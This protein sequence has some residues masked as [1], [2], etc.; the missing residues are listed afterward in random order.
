MKPIR[1]ST[2][3]FPFLFAEAIFGFVY[4]SFVIKWLVYLLS[5][6]QWAVGLT[7]LIIFH[8]FFLLCQASFFMTTFTDPGEIPEGFMENSGE[9]QDENAVG[10]TSESGL[11]VEVK[12]TKRKGAKRKCNKCT[13]IKP[14][15]SHHCSQCK[16][17]TLKMDHHCPWVNNCVGF[18][19][20]KFF[21]L[22][23]TWTVILGVF[24]AACLVDPSFQLSNQKE[25]DVLLFVTFIVTGVFG[26]GLG[27]F[28]L[29]HYAYTLMNQTTIEAMEKKS[30]LYT[31]NIYHLGSYRN[32]IEVFGDNPLLWFIPVFTSKGNG[33]SF[34]TRPIGEA[35][36]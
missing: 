36:A 17:C 7:Q 28:A 21:V 10:N 3:S 34:P 11:I 9:E 4:F 8:V 31:G 27:L 22:F 29:T 15:R 23:L 18:Y 25:R 20:Y 30:N 35:I 14:D 6:G 19:N 12:E 5:Q 24:V 2:G 13:K 32:F 1:L 33:L 26:V 16:R